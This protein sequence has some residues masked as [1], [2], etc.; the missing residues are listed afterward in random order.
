MG[1]RST[2]L[3]V[4]DDKTP[5]VQ[6]YRQFD[7]Y[8]SG[9]GKELVAFLKNK[10]LVNGISSR[11]PEEVQVNGMSDLAIRIITHLKNLH[12]PQNGPGNLYLTSLSSSPQ[13]Y[14]YTVY[15]KEIGYSDFF[16]QTDP[17]E[18]WNAPEKFKIAVKCESYGDVLFDDFVDNL[19]PENLE[20]VEEDDEEN[21]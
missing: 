12:D 8:P 14:H 5:M 6:F 19:D 11:M 13:S 15:A 16:P 17:N 4:E 7:G 20:P 3:I 1:T 9:H 21:D 10:V 18:F 2:T